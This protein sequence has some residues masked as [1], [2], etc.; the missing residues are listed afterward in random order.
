MG[1]WRGAAAALSAW[2]GPDARVEVSRGRVQM[3]RERSARTPRWCTSPGPPETSNLQIGSK[4]K[5]ICRQGAGAARGGAGIH[6]L[7]C[8]GSRYKWGG[9]CSR[10]RRRG[11][12][13]W[14][15]RFL[16]ET[17]TPESICSAAAQMPA[18]RPNCSAG[19]MVRSTGVPS[20]PGR[21]PGSRASQPG[22]RPSSIVRFERGCGDSSQGGVE[23]CRVRIANQFACSKVSFLLHFLPASTLSARDDPQKR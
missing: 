21:F 16:L 2:M 20:R 8:W 6:R 7:G 19:K 15:E 13:R 9:V 12:A 17:G 10:G 14:G 5:R 1:G 11:W 23:L 18:A 22:S 3:S 4:K